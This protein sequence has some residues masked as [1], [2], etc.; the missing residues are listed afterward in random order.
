MAESLP[1]DPLEELRTRLEATQRAA[2]RLAQE[3]V[4]AAR[5]VRGPEAGRVPPAG[6]EAPPSGAEASGE[7]QALVALLDTLRGV[8]PEDLQHQ[9]AEVV[10]QLLLLIRGLIDWWLSRL[11][12]SQRGQERPVEDI[13][14]G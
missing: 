7:L 13:P 9:L 3:T 8:L 2:E 11:E 6:W 10:R 14:I 4:E 5:R 1:D 12:P